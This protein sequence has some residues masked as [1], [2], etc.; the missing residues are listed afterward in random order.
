MKY[1][2]NKKDKNRSQELI[3]DVNHRLQRQ[4][5]IDHYCFVL[6]LAEDE[7]LPIWRFSLLLKVTFTSSLTI[8]AGLKL[9]RQASQS[10]RHWLGKW[11]LKYC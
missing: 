4:K 9:E 3:Q 8:L 7:Y 11:A 6:Q 5:Q 10:T 2:S 1:N